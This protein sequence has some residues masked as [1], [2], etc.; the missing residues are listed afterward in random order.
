M[1]RGTDFCGLNELSCSQRTTVLVVGR[2]G[3]L[4][5]PY[6]S[7]KS[8]YNSVV[9]EPGHPEVTGSSEALKH[10]AVTKNTVYDP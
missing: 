5:H 8:V 1:V 10:K 9:K 2:G 4:T 7:Y 6:T 3:S